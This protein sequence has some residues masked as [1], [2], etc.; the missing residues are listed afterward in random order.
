M[1]IQNHEFELKLQLAEINVILET[2][3]QRPYAE[4]YGLI[5]KLQRQAQGQ[6]PTSSA[7]MAQTV[8]GIKGTEGDDNDAR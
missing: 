3:G 4:V 2:L 7:T 8:T 5:Q 6:M 1:T